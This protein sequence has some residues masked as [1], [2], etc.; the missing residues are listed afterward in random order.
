MSFYLAALLLH[1]L[2]SFGICSALA[3]EWVVL[4][5][6]KRVRVVE[7]AREWVNVYSGLRWL[8][9]ISLAALLIPGFYMASI[10][11]REAAWISVALGSVFLLALIG[12]TLAGIRINKLKGAL[13]TRSGALPPELVAQARHPLLTLSLHL[14]TAIIASAVALMTF[15]PSLANSLLILLSG[16]IIGLSSGMMAGSFFRPKIVNVT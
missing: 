9:G 12:A 5:N 6:L 15:K 16:T 4:H 11:W 3:I 10:A 1:I 2:G 13:S 7:S 14:R 8:G